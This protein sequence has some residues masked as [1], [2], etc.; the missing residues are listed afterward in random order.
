[1][2]NSAMQGSL[3]L[4]VAGTEQRYAVA[5][6]ERLTI[7]RLNDCEIVLTDQAVSRR[8]FTVEARGETLLVTD[9]DSAN[10]TFVNERLIQTFTAAPGDKIRAGSVAFEVVGQGEARVVTLSGGT[11]R[12]SIIGSSAD[13]TL[14]PVI[15]KRFE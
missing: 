6:G 4:V 14:E 10:G 13:T 1:M 11:D 8:H 12:P 2:H 9:L 3:E 7:G 15:S 5:E